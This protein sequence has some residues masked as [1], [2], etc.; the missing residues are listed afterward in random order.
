LYSIA[1]LL[2]AMRSTLVHKNS[3]WISVGGHMHS[4]DATFPMNV[5]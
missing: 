3:I 2:Q 5:G 1:Y 4:L